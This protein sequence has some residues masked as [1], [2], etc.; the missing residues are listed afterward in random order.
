VRSFERLRSLDLGF[1]KES[2][3]EIHVYPKPGDYQNLDMNSYHQQLI[4][5]ISRVPGVHSVSF[6]DAPVPRAEIWHDTIARQC[7]Q[8]GRLSLDVPRCAKFWN[9]ISNKRLPGHV[10]S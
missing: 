5:R 8:L 4:D 3:L 2:V 9:I 6:S 7:W 1:E 10:S